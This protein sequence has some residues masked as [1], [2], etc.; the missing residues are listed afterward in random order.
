MIAEDIACTGCSREGSPSRVGAR[1]IDSL[2][3]ARLTPAGIAA[4]VG[5]M[6]LIGWGS[7]SILTRLALPATAT[8]LLTALG[9]HA[10]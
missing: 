2:A 6:V 5:S 3:V 8:N 10:R 9:R 4:A 1:V 7:D